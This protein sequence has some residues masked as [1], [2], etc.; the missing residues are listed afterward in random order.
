[1]VS[2]NNAKRWKIVQSCFRNR[3]TYLN[4]I[5]IQKQNKNTKVLKQNKTHKCLNYFERLGFYGGGE[6]GGT[7]G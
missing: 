6:G 4:K 3:K 1:M 7:Y 5:K 2:L